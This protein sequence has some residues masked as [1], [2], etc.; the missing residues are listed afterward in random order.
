MTSTSDQRTWCGR[1]ANKLAGKLCDVPG[2]REAGNADAKLWS[3]VR[4]G[5]LPL[6][7]QPA[8]W[9]VV[10]A[11][12]GVLVRAGNCARV[13]KPATKLAGRKAAASCRTPRRAAPALPVIVTYEKR[14]SGYS[15]FDPPRRLGGGPHPDP[16]SD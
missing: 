7:H 11:R 16:H 5:G 4:R 15:R 1:Q 10:G 13:R 8:C 12:H 14:R 2:G 9:L 6:F 3:A